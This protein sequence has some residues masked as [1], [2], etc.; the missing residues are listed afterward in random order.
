MC[1]PCHLCH[2][3]HCQP[4]RPGADGAAR[5]VDV[6][7]GTAAGLRGI[8]PGLFRCKSRDGHLGH[9]RA[10]HPGGD[11]RRNGLYPDHPQAGCLVGIRAGIA[12]LSPAGPEKCAHPHVGKHA[13]IRP[14]GRDDHPDRFHRHVGAVEP[15][16][17]RGQSARLLF[18]EVQRRNCPGLRPA[19]F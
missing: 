8:W 12:S 3:D 7:L 1:G 5:P 17:G 4:P 14:Q 18:W 10:R 11:D 15:A 16:L 13:R 9:V 19:R 2:T 6:M